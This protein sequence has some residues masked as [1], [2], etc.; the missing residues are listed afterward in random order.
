MRKKFLVR[1]DLE[2]SKLREILGPVLLSVQ[3]AT[4][5]VIFR[6]SEGVVTFISMKIGGNLGKYVDVDVSEILRKIFIWNKGSVKVLE[7]MLR[8]NG[9]EMVEILSEGSK[10]FKL[11]T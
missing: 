6:T 3:K 5:K 4:H 1:G 11:K 10:T 9:V 2:K 8:Q 7:E